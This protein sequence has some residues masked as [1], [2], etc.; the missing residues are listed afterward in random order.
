MVI[1]EMLCIELI[2]EK[3]QPLWFPIT[4]KNGL[5]TPLFKESRKNVHK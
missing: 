3:S 4:G 2:H 5:V 1:C